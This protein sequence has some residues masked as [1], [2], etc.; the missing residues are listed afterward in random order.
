[1]TTTQKNTISHKIAKLFVCLIV[2]VFTLP[3]VTLLT[4]AAVV[5]WFYGEDLLSDQLMKRF[6]FIEHFL[7]KVFTK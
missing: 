3:G 7:P 5:V 1:M 2:I 4:V 6:E